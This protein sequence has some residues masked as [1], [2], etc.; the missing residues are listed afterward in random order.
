MLG[1]NISVPIFSSGMRRA[2]VGQ[3]KIELE[4]TKNTKDEASKGLKLAVHQARIDFSSAFDK[5]LN[6]KESVE[7]ARK[8]F[9]NT[10]VRYS[11][12]LAGS[13]ELTQA[14]DQLVG[15]QTAYIAAMVELLNA[16]LDL[17]KALGNI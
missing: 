15:V 11:N 10:S 2:R 5:Y 13:F 6:Q 12:G 9:D 16:K 3:N 7:L 14:S 4:K 1:V 17:D 8:V